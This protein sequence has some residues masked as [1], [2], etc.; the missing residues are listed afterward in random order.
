[1]VLFLVNNN[2]E[3]SGGPFR[4]GEGSFFTVCYQYYQCIVP[5]QQRQSSLVTVPNAAVKYV[6]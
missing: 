3:N 2:D 5:R 6:N 1:M 4:G